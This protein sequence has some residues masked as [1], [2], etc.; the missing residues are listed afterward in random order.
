MATTMEELAKLSRG[1]SSH[2]TQQTL[3]MLSNLEAYMT[4]ADMSFGF[5]L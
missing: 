4:T 2:M 1:F 5:S 3:D